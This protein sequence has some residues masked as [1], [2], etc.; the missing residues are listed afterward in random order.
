MLCAFYTFMLR[1]YSGKN[2]ELIA[3]VSAGTF[4]QEGAVAARPAACCALALLAAAVRI[5]AKR[6][7]GDVVRSCSLINKSS[8]YLRKY[9]S[10]SGFVH[11]PLPK[12]IQSLSGIKP[13]HSRDSSLSQDLYKKINTYV[14]PT[15]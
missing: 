6:I 14:F 5:G 12:V 7:C 1:I 2:W 4:S 10:W 8:C 13:L 15:M 11:S 3:E 9:F